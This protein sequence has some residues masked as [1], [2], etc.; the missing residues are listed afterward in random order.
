M[1]IK[2]LGGGSFYGPYGTM[3]SYGPNSVIDIDNG[4]KPSVAYWQERVD[5]GA[6]E[7]LEAPTDAAAKAAAR[8]A[9]KAEA[10]TEADEPPPMGGP[11]SGREAWVA[12]A[13]GVGV[14]VTE[15]MTRDDIVEAV[16]GKS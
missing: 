8:A 3:V 4:D 10:A 16:E 9:A 12:Y 2:L 7:L 15:D 13:A 1:K 5:A 11:G 6:A 14:E